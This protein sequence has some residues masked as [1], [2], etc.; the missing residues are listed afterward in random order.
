MSIQINFVPL[1]QQN[2][3]TMEQNELKVIFDNLDKMKRNVIERNIKKY[4]NGTNESN[5]KRVDIWLQ[6]KKGDDVSA[7]A[8]DLWLSPKGEIMTSL[9][10]CCG[11]AEPYD[12]MDVPLRWW[13]EIIWELVLTKRIEELI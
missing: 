5:K 3:T 1:H 13:R 10:W 11:H 2:N 6:N 7:M 12:F 9:D 4:L 8:Q